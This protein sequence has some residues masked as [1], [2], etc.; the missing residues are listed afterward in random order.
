PE[1]RERAQAWYEAKRRAL[2]LPSLEPEAPEPEAPS[3][4]PALDECP[5]CETRKVFVDCEVKIF[6]ERITVCR[7]CLG[8]PE[9]E[10]P[11]RRHL[12]ALAEA[13]AAELREGEA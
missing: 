11:G 6:G 4:E 8:H 12:L 9:L 5:I 1:L 2:G 13:R 7:S 10:Q 3:G